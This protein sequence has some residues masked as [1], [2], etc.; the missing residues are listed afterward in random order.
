[1]V[2]GGVRWQD[3]REFVVALW[4]YCTYDKNALTMFAF[5]LYDLDASGL[6]GE[7]VSVDNRH[8]LRADGHVDR[9]GGDAGDREGGKE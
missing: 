9:R 1:M 5:D 7:R 4:S 6:I 2:C 3:F 8:T